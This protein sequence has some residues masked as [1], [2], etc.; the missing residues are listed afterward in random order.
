MDWEKIMDETATYYANLSKVPGWRDY[1]RQQVRDMESE[2]GCWSGL[3]LMVRKKL[4][5][6]KEKMQSLSK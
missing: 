6:E 4:E 5:D 1:C 2:N 3:L